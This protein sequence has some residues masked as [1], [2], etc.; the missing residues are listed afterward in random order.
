MNE[1]TISEQ[2]S[3]LLASRPADINGLTEAERNAII[4]SAIQVD[5]QWVIVSRYCDDV[6]QLEGMPSNVPAGS[7][8]I[9]FARVPLAF[10]AVMKAMIYRYMRRGR[11][12]FV[13][14][15]GGMVRQ[16]FAC[17]MPFLLYLERLNIA[18][19]GAITPMVCNSY[20]ELCKAHRQAGKSN[21]PLSQGTLC[22]RFQ[23]IEALHELSQCTDQ[24][25]PQHPWPDTSAMSMVGLNGSGAHH[26]QGGKTPL[27]PD[28]IFCKLFQ[29]A[30]DCLERGHELL[31]LRDEFS[32]LEMDRNNR[33]F[34]TIIKRKNLFLENHGWCGGLQEFNS[35]LV[36]LR[37]ASYIILASTSGCR[38]HEIANLQLGSHHHTRD[39]EG[40]IFHWMR[41][42]SEKTDAGI[43]S[44]MIPE[45]AVRAL[46]LM[47]RW[48][49]PLRAMIHDEIVCRRR[50]HP[51][52]PEIVEAQ[53]H[54]NALFLGVNPKQGNKVRTLSTMSLGTGL[55]EFAKTCG[56]DWNLASH[57]FRRKFANYAAHS[58]FGDL[59]YLKE[60]YAHW[61]MDMTLGYAMDD[62]WGQHLDLELYEEVRSELSNLKTQVVDSWLQ[63]ENLG[64]GYGA[65]LKR[66]QRDPQNLLIF[67]DR[68][69]ML[70]S[71][72]ESTSIRSN[73]HAWCTADNIDC[74][75]NNQERTR[76]SN[77][78]N[79][80]IGSEHVGL[81]KTLYTNLK[82]LLDCHDIGEGGRLRVQ[83]D[84]NRCIDVLVQLGISPED[85]T[86]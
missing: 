43:I 78:S 83:R 7:K 10:R 74:I 84:L 8:R 9:S 68:S 38:H 46:R 27:I 57:Q 80:V 49:N 33:W 44:W 31:D 64:G 45:V 14:P 17:V 23:A 48:S 1:T 22:S 16:F 82:E 56:V 26:K 35:A 13:R 76:C 20:V 3:V 58:K 47:E 54:R 50:S 41:S 51:L 36:D 55:K 72:S 62:S 71:I 11:L 66:W 77:C 67:K 63:N 24:P 29:K 4:I 5:D 19:L 65:S 61:S 28:D 2:R 69:G 73:G 37:T 40:N 79:A 18:N 59:R 12:G 25:I 34:T 32:S 85:F 75:G 52:D 42:K 81:Y 21:K 30:H 15:K 70:K 60:H 53:K 6:W 39:D 86:S